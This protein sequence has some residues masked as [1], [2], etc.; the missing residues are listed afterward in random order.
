MLK[1]SS[2]KVYSVPKHLNKETRAIYK[3]LI[4]LLKPLN[5]LCDL[6]INLLIVVADS[7]YQ[8]NKARTDINK[9]GQVI[10]IRDKEGNI[11][12]VSKKPSVDVFKNYEGIF[13]AACTQ[14][15]L[16]PSARAKLGS[17]MAAFIKELKES[18]T[19][20]K[21]VTKEDIELAWLVNQ[22]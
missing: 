1:T 20:E 7:I 13:R 4:E 22:N 19:E 11:T 9:N 17:E 8:M 6:D 3:E 16:S 15:Y 18:E 5:L 10:Y 21:E 12:K 2:D 14:L